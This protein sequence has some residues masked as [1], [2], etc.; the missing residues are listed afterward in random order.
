MVGL[1][2]VGAIVA[3]A[4]IVLSGGSLAAPVLALVM[5]IT[6]AAEAGLGGTAAIGA[7]EA[8]AEIALVVDTA[9]APGV[10]SAVATGTTE[11]VATVAVQSAAATTTTS[12]SA[13]TVA[14]VVTIAT[15]SA[16]TLSSDSPQSPQHG[17]EPTC[18]VPIVLPLPAPKS[19]DLEDYAD[20]ID[21]AT[22]ACLAHMI[23][24]VKPDI[25]R[26]VWWA[27]MQ[28]AIRPDVFARGIA[29]GLTR[30]EVIF[31][32]WLR[33]GASMAF[34]VDHIIEYQ[35]LP[36]GQEAQFDRPTNYRLMDKTSNAISGASL[37]AGIGHLRQLLANCHDPRATTPFRFESVAPMGAMV[38]EIWTRAEI[39]TG[40]HLDA[41]EAMNPPP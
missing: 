13:S 14:A 5:A 35:V 19:Q 9:A 20:H 41:Y 25:Q 18:S 21:P 8:G 17:D 24:R 27:D 38:P 34:E 28:V 39:I 37:A 1:V 10:L 29:L 4:V 26:D 16:T 32:T 12:A 31:P 36:I 15:A 3:G 7:L 33:H 22:P 2:V 11:A 40:R 23:G 6:P 30:D